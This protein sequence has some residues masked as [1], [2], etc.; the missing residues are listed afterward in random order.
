MRQASSLQ[1]EH[2]PANILISDSCPSELWS[3]FLLS[4]ITVFVVICHGSPGNEYT[5]L[6]PLILHE[7]RPVSSKYLSFTL[8]ESKVT[9]IKQTKKS[10]QMPNITYLKAKHI[11]VYQ[12]WLY[13]PLLARIMRHELYGETKH[14]RKWLEVIWKKH[15]IFF[16]LTTRL[17]FPLLSLPWIILLCTSYNLM[18]IVIH[19]I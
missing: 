3:K 13:L 15:F 2:G 5:W 6:L 11:S 8:R 14:P 18:Q 10:K 7:S 9:Q 12:I 1:K 4:Q 16:F 17:H 19:P